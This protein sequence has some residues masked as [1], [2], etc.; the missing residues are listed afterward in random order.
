MTLSSPPPGAGCL[1]IHPLGD[2]ALVIELADVV[3]EAATARARSVADRLAQLAL[4]GVREAVPAF[5]SVTVHYDPVAVYQ[6]GP[7]AE[8]TLPF[9][10]LRERLLRLLAAE[11]TPALASGKFVEI[12]VCYGG[13]YGEDLGALALARELAPSKV[14]ELHTAPT[15]FVGMLGFMPGFPYLGGLDE[16][17]V[18]PR[19]ATPRPRVPR[20]SVAIGGEHTGIYPMESPG[21][22]HLIGR[23]PLALFDL[24]HSPPS[25]L[26]VGDRVRFVAIQADEFE[27]RASGVSGMA[28][29]ETTRWD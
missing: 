1:A 17:L 3:S 24:T 20:G 18:S 4:P 28:A 26:Q 27:R 14:I 11:G 2:R 12:P 15:Y 22:W 13:L 6:T 29:A 5:C 8:S 23:T 25:L 19:R 16:R 7:R 21:G 10:L 9:E